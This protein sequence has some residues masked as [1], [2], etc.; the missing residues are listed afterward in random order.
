MVQFQACLH[1]STGKRQEDF[2]PAFIRVP[3]AS[4]RVAVLYLVRSFRCVSWLT[5][6][7]CLTFNRTTGN[8][9]HAGTGGLAGLT[10]QAAISILMARAGLR[11]SRAL[12]ANQLTSARQHADDYRRRTDRRP[13][14]PDA[15][16]QSPEWPA[17]GRDGRRAIT[18]ISRTGAFPP[19]GPPV[20]RLKR[21]SPST[22]M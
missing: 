14:C 5:R 18:E 1:L 12:L 10:L 7:S 15:R 11:R 2:N 4:I 13:A 6:I 16:H 17:A 21:R 22:A 3:S 9:G 19:L 20:R 8:G